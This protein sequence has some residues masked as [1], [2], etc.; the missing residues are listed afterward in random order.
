VTK[1]GYRITGVNQKEHAFS[2]ADQDHWTVLELE[3]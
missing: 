1:F 2:L 3:L